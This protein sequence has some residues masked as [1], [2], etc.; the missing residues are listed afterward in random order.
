MKKV[1][2]SLLFILFIISSCVTVK[3]K[4]F[5]AVDFWDYTPLIK[6][7]LFVTESN[8]VNFDYTA[9][10]SVYIEIRAGED[11]DKSKAVK[12]EQYLDSDIYIQKNKRTVEYT[13]A[14]ID[15]ALKKLSNQLSD[16]GANG[17]INL[18]IS[19][20]SSM[21]ISPDTYY[22]PGYIITGMAI[23]K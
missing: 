2:L 9:I 22:G 7:G 3:F 12:K 21:Q 20:V 23:K 19:Q 1:L 14:T 13:S 11:K 4:S 18:K 5:E 15:D 17:I 10:G 6:K 8:S 16:V